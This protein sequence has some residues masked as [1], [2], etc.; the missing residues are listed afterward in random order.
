M[1]HFATAAFSRGLQ[2]FL[3]LLGAFCCH[4]AYGQPLSIKDF[5]LYGSNSV[6][7]N[8]STSIAGG[9]IGSSNLFRTIGNTTITA[10]IYSGGRVDLSNSNTITGNISAQNLNG[11]SGYIFQTGSNAAITGNLNIKGNVLLGGGF[12]NGTV[13]YEGTYFGSAPSGGAVAQTLTFRTLPVLPVANTFSTGSTDIITTRSITPGVYKDVK[14]PGSK[15]LTFSGAGNYYFNSIKNSGNFNSFVLDFENN[16]TAVMR[17]FVSG[18][19]DLYKLTVSFPRGGDASRVYMQVMGTGS[20]APDGTTAWTISNGAS[21]SKRSTWFGTVYAP[22]GSINI[23]SGSSESKIVGA[24]WSGRSITMQTGVGIS[25]VRLNDCNPNAYA[26]P[27]RQI[28]CLN[29]TTQLMGSSSSSNAQYSWSK[30]DGTLLGT[31]QN[32]TVGTVGQYVLSVFSADCIFPATDTTLVTGVRCVLPYYPPPPTGKEYLKIGAELNSLYLNY[33]NVIDSGKAMFL[34]VDDKVLIDVIVYEGNRA[35][36]QSMLQTTG[37]GM[38]GF[39]NNGPDSLKITGFYPIANLNKFDLEPMRSL[40][41]FVMPVFPPVGNGGIAQSAG[42]SAMRTNFVRNGFNLSGEGIKIGVLSD[43]YNTLP[44]DP[45]TNDVNNGDLPGAGNPVNTTPVEVLLD[46]PY[47]PKSDEG[48]AMLQIVHDVAPKSALA[49][50]TGF[51]SPGD[52][53]DGIGALTAA[54]CKVIVDDITFITE[55][56]FKP[57]V[58]SK[59]YQAATASGVTCVSAA[60]NFA[61]KSYEGIF[62]P[63]PGAAPFGLAGRAHNFG[64]G[65]IFQRDSVKGS[66]DHPQTY[67]IVLQWDENMYS[68]GGNTGVV[69]DL[70]AYSVDQLGN[71]IGFNRYNVGGDPIEV[72]TLTVTQNSIIDLLIVNS[73]LDAT[74][75]TSNVRF[76]Y[77]VFRGDLKINEFIQGATTIVGH[78]NTPEIITVAAA[79]YGNTPAFGVPTPTRSNFSSIGGTTYLGSTSPKPDI[80]GPNGVNTT[81]AFGSIDYESDGLP[82]FFGTSAAAPHVA[83]AAALLIQARQK[84]YNQVLSPAGV[85][86]LLISN[87]ISMDVPGFDYKT[88]YGFVQADSA[89]RTLANPTP[90]LTGL[91]FS[92]PSLVPGAQPMDVTVLGNYLSSST[93]IILGSDTLPTTVINNNTAIATLPAFDGVEL[94][95]SYTTPKSPSGLDG[96]L[97][98]S[99]SI[100]GIIKKNITIKADNKSKKYGA[101]FPAFTATIF[102]NNDSLQHTNLTLQDLGLTNLSFSTNAQVGDNVGLY[103]IM[104]SRTFDPSNAADAALLEKYNYDSL[105]GVLSIERLPVTVSPRDTTLVYGQAI[106]NIHFNYQVDPSITLANPASTQGYIQ[107]SHQSQL[108]NDVIAFANNR[109]VAVING[110]LVEVK[111]ELLN[112]VP[113]AMVGGVPVAIVGGVPVAIVGGVPVAI[114]NYQ[115]IQ[116]ING[117]PVVVSATLANGVPVAI[118]GGVPVAMVGGVPV[119]MV[120]SV[121][122]GVPVAIVG[123]VPVAIVNGLADSVVS[124]E[125]FM[126]DS[127]AIHNARTIT[128]QYAPPGGVPVTQI[129]RVVD[130]TQESV[131][132]YNINPDTTTTSMINSIE[133]SNLRG[134]LDANQLINGVPVAMVGGVPVA[135]VSGVPVAIVGGV[136]VAIVGGVPVAIVNSLTDSNKL[137]VIIDSTDLGDTG[138]SNFKSINLI[139]GITAGIQTIVPGALLNDN[140][141]VHYE[142]GNLNILPAPLTIKARD[143]AKLYGVEIALDST[144][145]TITSGRLMYEDSIKYVHLSSQGT[146]ASATG[147]TY[148]IVP[149]TAVGGNNTNLSNYAITYVNGT[150]TLNP[151][152]CLLTHNSFTNFGSTTRSATSLWLNITTKVSGQLS[153]DGDFLLFTGGAVTFNNITS[154]TVVNNLSMPR[155]KIMADRKATVPYTT[156]DIAKSMWITRVPVGFSST[157][158]IFISGV[159][160][161]SSNGFTK[162][163]GANSVVKGM[164]YSNRSF[165]DQWSYGIAAYQPPFDYPILAD[166]GK[167]TSINGT[168]RAGTPVPLLNFLVNGGSGGGGNN[169][170]GSSSSFDKFTAC[171]LIDPSI[172]SNATQRI[173]S[174]SSEAVAE[175][176]TGRM[177]LFPNPTV[178]GFSIAFKPAVT[179]LSTIRMYNMQGEVVKTISNGYMEAGKWI[180]KDVSTANLSPGVYIVQLQEQ[181]K[182]VNKKLIISAKAF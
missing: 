169:Y 161:T 167:V 98:N 147:S 160:I 117:L 102:V 122:N 67:T 34:I 23:G 93:K 180:K 62:N 89:A 120:S 71:V 83:A 3:L 136:P 55:P 106:G 126:A 91:Q 20:T 135:I 39:L 113:V 58:V 152:P 54:H 125:S 63:A 81:V 146:L 134:L 70:D 108:A 164:F 173:H 181:G 9:S 90:V 150:L 13:N 17:I 148:P 24:L 119:A 153:A 77:V 56:Y 133:S 176:G 27:D 114:V 60:G 123:G 156:Y 18:D 128:N 38:T 139:T 29:P 127:A 40:I 157:S 116:V 88:G 21:G 145:F 84:F 66:P 51:I 30:L 104:A 6:E 178:S 87:A 141:E 92:D 61:D 155:G 72:L 53:A 49:Y 138:P 76:K 177:E 47:G 31:S 10:N 73:S 151:N 28:D 43:S 165:T 103:R 149:S 44:G 12:I 95:S 32:I 35:I 115:S 109:P 175:N 11:A 130:L 129:T 111:N 124:N 143:T 52:F 144:A 57:G 14:L 162:K 16:P 99:I 75:T 22:K 137:P 79:F 33:G 41:N 121:V 101:V 68:L 42:D 110:Q 158:D 65:D 132:N 25:F 97:S 182:V 85:K 170:T 171:L 172:V 5:V 78:G 1:R 15:T 50:R 7:L 48:R 94:L 64:G 107:L 86:S 154:A 19:V 4:D 168:Y 46:Y 131:L 74:A 59:A 45:A 82:N 26:G 8:T 37:Y 140:L 36:V 105:P 80:T 179:G 159:I 100:T 112:G 174:A 2:L 96:G 163:N 118:V 142:L 69:S 166:S